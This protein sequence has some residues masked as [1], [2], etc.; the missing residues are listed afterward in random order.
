MRDSAPL[1][2]RRRVTPGMNE[3]VP[4][5]PKSQWKIRSFADLP[6]SLKQKAN[7]LPPYLT[8]RRAAE[9]NCT[10]RAGLYQHADMDHVK[11]VRDGG[12]RL[13]ETMSILLRLANLPATALSPPKPIKA[14][15]PF[16]G[17][18]CADY[19]HANAVAEHAT[20]ESVDATA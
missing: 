20:P 5:L 12:N 19:E 8:T 15:P 4:P 16:S 17:P 13:W 14:L 11:S 1:S 6:D 10:S 9:L 3:R 7:E 2:H 18:S